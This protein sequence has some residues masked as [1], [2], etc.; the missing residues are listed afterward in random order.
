MRGVNGRI[1]TSGSQLTHWDDR[2]EACGIR[3]DKMIFTCQW[4]TSTSAHQMHLP[5]IQYQAYVASFESVEP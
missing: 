3:L 4:R 5:S 2:H 1:D